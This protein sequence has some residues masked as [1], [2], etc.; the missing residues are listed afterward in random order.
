MDANE[1]FNWFDIVQVK[2][3]MTNSKDIGC[4]ICMEPLKEMVCPRITKCGHIYCWPCVL[5]YLDFEQEHNWKKCPLC[6]DPVYKYDLKNVIVSQSKYYKPGN[7]IKF[8]LMVRSKG[9]NLAKNKHIEH[10]QI[11]EMN[12]LL[13]SDQEILSSSQRKFLSHIQ[14]T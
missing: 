12:S 3:D 4:P 11:S 8:D 2:M 13:A 5:Q 6:C 9:S 10:L 14:K 7:L 1:K